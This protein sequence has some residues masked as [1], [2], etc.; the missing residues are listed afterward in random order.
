MLSKAVIVG[1]VNKEPQ[2]VNENIIVFQVIS[3]TG[4]HAPRPIIFHITANGKLAEQAKE[5]KRG[6]LVLIDAS[7]STT[8][9]G[10]PP[11]HMY[12]DGQAYTQYDVLAEKIVILPELS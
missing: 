2:R 9:Q 8:P 1:S 11:M 3:R 12:S 6:N 10:N 7:F 5:L 4:N